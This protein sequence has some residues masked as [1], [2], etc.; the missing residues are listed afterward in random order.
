MKEFKKT[1]G[2]VNLGQVAALIQSVSAEPLENNATPTVKNVGT[3]ANAAFVFGIP[4][5]TPTTD[6]VQGGN[7]QAVT[8]NG[9]YDFAFDKSK[10]RTGFVVNGAADNDNWTATFST[11]FA[12]S[13]YFTIVTPVSSGANCPS[14]WYTV[15]HSSTGFKLF[16]KGTAPTGGFQYLAIHP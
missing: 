1:M 15:S 4:T 13:N 8:S 3:K 2:T 14:G 10:I 7:E 16:C 5:P 6:A 11:P 9:V 12:D